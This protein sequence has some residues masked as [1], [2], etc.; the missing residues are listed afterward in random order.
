MKRISLFL[1]TLALTPLF[2]DAQGIQ[3]TLINGATPNSVIVRIKNNTAAAISGNL[4]SMRFGIRIPDQGAGNPTLT[5][6][7]LMATPGSITYPAPYTENTFHYYDVSAVINGGNPVAIPVGGELNAFN[8]T[9]ANGV[10]TSNVELVGRF[11]DGTP[12]SA[13]ANDATEFYV[14][15]DGANSTDQT[16]RFY[17]NGT[18]SVG[19]SNTPT[20]ST[21]GLGGVVLPVTFTH[22]EANRDGANALVTWGTA[23]ETNNQGFDIERSADGKAFA[24]IGYQRSLAIGGN[25]DEKLEYSFT[26]SKPLPGLN[27]Y[28]LK[29]LDKDGKATYSK[30]AQVIFGGAGAVK[31]F[32]N[33]ANNGKVNVDASGVQSIEVFTLTGQKLNVP[34]TYGTNSHELNI[35]SLASGSYTV[36]I[37]TATGAT[38]EKLVVR[39]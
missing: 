39:H 1:S 8:V 15:I 21:V 26:D 33:P 10:G 6:T 31:V 9:F 14:S 12:G 16:T 28:R 27:Q 24:K 13:G 5:A 2:A 37:N 35:S 38:T 29:Q 23:S 32:P 34:V 20:I 17:G 25:S 11:F 18:N 30:V 22:I 3:G 36:R 19:L 7:S 4:V